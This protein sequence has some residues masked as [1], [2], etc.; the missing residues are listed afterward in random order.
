MEAKRQVALMPQMPTRQETFSGM[1]QSSAR[2][3]SDFPFFL[4]GLNP[5]TPAGEKAKGAK[6]RCEPLIDAIATA[7]RGEE[8]H[9]KEERIR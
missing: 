9:P 1:G 3:K 2:L 7:S 6:A 4:G 8:Q 5:G